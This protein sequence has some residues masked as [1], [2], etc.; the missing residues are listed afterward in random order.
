MEKG[1]G[2]WFLHAERLKHTFRY[3]EQLKEKKVNVT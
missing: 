2:G 3:I 1:D